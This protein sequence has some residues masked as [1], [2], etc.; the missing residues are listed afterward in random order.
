M[1][2]GRRKI[3]G[4]VEACHRKMVW[5]NWDAFFMKKRESASSRTKAAEWLMLTCACAGN[6]C[7]ANTCGR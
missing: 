6:T 2:A 5:L 4:L 3:D 1:L 7:G